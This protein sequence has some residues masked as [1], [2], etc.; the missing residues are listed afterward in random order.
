MRMSMSIMIHSSRGQRY[1]KQG[2]T[3]C[4]ISRSRINKHRIF[5]VA[6]STTRKLLPSKVIAGILFWVNCF[7]TARSCSPFCGENIIRC[8]T[9]LLSSSPQSIYLVYSII[10]I[11]VQCWVL[12]LEIISYGCWFVR[13]TFTFSS[14]YVRRIKANSTQSIV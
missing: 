6:R 2:Q 10:I 12:L 9:C 11:V 1:C 14:K 13:Y 4:R 8:R 7:T 5:V 3:K